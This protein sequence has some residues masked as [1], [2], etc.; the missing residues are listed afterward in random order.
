MP[1]SSKEF[2]D[3]QSTTECRFTL[4]RVRETFVHAV[5]SFDDEIVH[6]LCHIF[7]NCGIT[8][9]PSSSNIQV[10]ILDAGKK[11]IIHEPF[12]RLK[13]FKI[14][15]GEFW[16]ILTVTEIDVIYIYIYIIPR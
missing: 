15:L 5:R 8:N 16:N 14:R 10:M 2:L 4:K 7:S 9:L 12:F 13:N 6:G 3:I 11:L 1:V